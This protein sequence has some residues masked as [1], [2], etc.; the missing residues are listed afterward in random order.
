MADKRK[1][2][3]KPQETATGSEELRKAYSLMGFS[4]DVPETDPAELADRETLR[5]VRAPI[6]PEPRA[7]GSEQ[8]EQI[9]ELLEIEPEETVAR[10]RH[11]WDPNLTEDQ[12]RTALANARALIDRPARFVPMLEAAATL[13]RAPAPLPDCFDFPGMDLDEIPINPDDHKF[14]YLVVDLCWIVF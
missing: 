14:E 11:G 10:L 3:I 2:R 5:A 13:A 6:V 12:L 4:G 7:L 8:L 9:E 1:T